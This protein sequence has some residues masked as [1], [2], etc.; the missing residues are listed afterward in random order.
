[1]SA[2]Q[3]ATTEQKNKNNKAQCYCQIIA[4]QSSSWKWLKKNWKSATLQ[5]SVHHIV[6][7]PPKNQTVTQSETLMKKIEFNCP[8]CNIYYYNNE[9]H[10]EIVNRHCPQCSAVLPVPPS[11][12]KVTLGDKKKGCPVCETYIKNN[13]KHQKLINKYCQLCGNNLPAVVKQTELTNNTYYIELIAVYGHGVFYIT[14]DLKK[15]VK[16]CNKLAA[17]DCD[18]HH[19]WIVV[20][21]DESRVNYPDDWDKL[22]IVHTATK[23]G[24][25]HWS[26]KL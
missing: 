2:L 12:T 6:L 20:E 9:T 8:D 10:G 26:N 23:D 18:S 3:L 25:P 22:N 15:A 1:M 17:K 13:Q 7:I 24:K 14:T 19:K 16:K 21:F 11:L 4:V 5:T